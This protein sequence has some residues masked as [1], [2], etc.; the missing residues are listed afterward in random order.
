MNP[1]FL[2]LGGNLGNRFSHIFSAISMINGQI[3]RIGR[4]SSFYVTEPWG[5]K[6]QPWFLNVALEVNTNL[7]PLKLL[8]QLKKIEDSLGR[9][10]SEKW[11]PRILDI[12]ILLYKDSILDLPGLN[13]PH[14]HL[15][16][17]RFA[18]EPLNEIAS[19]F[20]HPLLKKEIGYILSACGDPTLVYKL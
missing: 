20:E 14:K 4:S 16:E 6:N 11:G 9:Q 7:D 18:L 8:T 15:H 13:I 10:P 1:V 12:D 3:G 19:E 5:L 17:R 2:L